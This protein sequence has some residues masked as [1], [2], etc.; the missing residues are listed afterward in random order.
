MTHEKPVVLV[1]R[2]YD[3]R[4]NEAI[5]CFFI[6]QGFGPNFDPLGLA[7]GCKSLIS[8]PALLYS[9]VRIPIAKHKVKTIF[10]IAHEDCAAYCDVV[11]KEI[12]KDVLICDMKL[13]KDEINRFFPQ[14]EVVL[15][16][17]DLVKDNE[18]AEFVVSII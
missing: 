3:Y 2:C 6:K 17:A 13:V 16:F 12:E 1:I 14:V 5:R 4:L 9:Q 7:G 15:C 11:D 18:T 10:L 8:N